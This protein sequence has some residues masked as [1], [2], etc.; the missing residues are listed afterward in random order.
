METK[1]ERMELLASAA[2]KKALLRLGLPTLA[3][4][5]ISALYN[6]VDAFFVGQLGGA[7][8]AAVSLFAPIATAMLGLA[9]LFGG[10][11]ASYISRLLGAGRQREA[12]D[13][14]TTSLTTAAAVALVLILLAAL[15]VEPFL[16]G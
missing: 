3:A 4:L 7:P 16:R 1:A 8:M 6:V 12:S 14:A 10:G 2:V 11:A 15:F 13:C 5:G 9:L